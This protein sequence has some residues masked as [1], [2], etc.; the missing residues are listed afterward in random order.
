MESQQTIQILFNP[1]EV[2][3]TLIELPNTNYSP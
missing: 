2:D 1:I 3:T